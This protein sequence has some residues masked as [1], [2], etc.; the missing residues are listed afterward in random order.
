MALFAIHG[1]TSSMKAALGSK[2]FCSFFA[3]QALS[4]KYPSMSIWSISCM[5]QPDFNSVL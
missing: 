1:H 3:S 5:R 4:R 2:L